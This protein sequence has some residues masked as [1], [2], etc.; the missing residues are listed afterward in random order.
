MTRPKKLIVACDGTWM[1]SDNGFVRD[2]YWPWDTNG[3]LQVPSNVTR[4]CRALL[5]Q[6]HNKEAIQQVVY[7]QAGI[8][9]QNNVYDHYFGGFTGEGMSENIRE[10]YGFLSANYEPGDEIHLVGFSRGAFTARSIAGL[11]ADLGLLTRVGMVEFYPTF[12]DWEN[13]LVKGYVS[14]WPNRPFPKKPAFLG[15]N[16]VSELERRGLTSL[17][18]PIK[19]IGVWDTVGSLGIPNCGLWPQRPPEYAFI[20]TK[21]SANVEYAFHALALDEHRK[22]FSPTIWEKPEGQTLPYKLY[23]CW[24]PGVHSN[25]GGGYD[26]TETADITLAWMISQFHELLDFDPDYVTWQ[27]DLNLKFYQAQTPSEIRGWGT[28]KLYNSFTGIEMLAGCKTRTPGQYHATDPVTGKEVPRLLHDTREHI[29][30]CVRVRMSLHGKGA[31]DHGV[32]KPQALKKFQ[33]ISPGEPANAYGL[34]K[35]HQYDDRFR[36][37]FRAPTGRVVVLPESRLG[38]VEK[39]LLDLFPAAKIIAEPRR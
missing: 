31:E 39:K 14:P 33:L 29:H 36:W 24:F 17:R 1:N 23:Q 27:H 8:G 15:S 10:A 11:I 37:V 3:T 9:S 34:T 26:D 19:A 28:G 20:D 13:Q 16:Y 2:S 35:D 7:Y 4:F 5:P 32:Y 22:P 25:V 38:D 21:V 18:I 12:K 30:P 6:S